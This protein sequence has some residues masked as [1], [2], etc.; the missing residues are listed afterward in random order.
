MIIVSESNG[1]PLKLISAPV[2]IVRLD[3]PVLEKVSTF[4]SNQ[5]TSLFPHCNYLVQTVIVTRP[6]CAIFS[7]SLL[8][9]PVPPRSVLPTFCP[10]SFIPLSKVFPFRKWNFAV[11]A[12]SSADMGFSLWR[13]KPIS[14][15]S[16]ENL[17][18]SPP[19]SPRKGDPRSPGGTG[20][21]CLWPPF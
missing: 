12:F 15:S 5:P 14:F 8:L 1:F 13:L 21:T 19:S 3:H 11:P 4:L 20:P 6:F 9:D 18:P 17:F 2:P 7:F 10:F 16:G